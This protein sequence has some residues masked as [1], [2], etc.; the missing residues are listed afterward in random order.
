[1]WENL[2]SGKLHIREK[3]MYALWILFWDFKKSAFLQGR[4]SYAGSTVYV[5]P[6]LL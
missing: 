5:K 2:I 3:L 1:M 4:T 6:P